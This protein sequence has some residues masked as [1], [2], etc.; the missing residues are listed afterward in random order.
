MI[1]DTLHF[2][3][4]HVKSPKVCLIG[5]SL[6]G[7]QFVKFATLFP[8]RVDRVIMLDI[9]PQKKLAKPNS[10]SIITEQFKQIADLIKKENIQSLEEAKKRA[11]EVLSGQI[12]EERFRIGMLMGL[13]VRE[14]GE[15]N[16]RLV[17][18]KNHKTQNDAKE[19]ISLPKGSI[20]IR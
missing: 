12:K 17:F 6:S 8:E 18:D 20:W 15:I 1:S 9:H 16:W 13:V 10:V 14:N 11:D 4:K 3:E 2:I 7:I 5:H 19:A